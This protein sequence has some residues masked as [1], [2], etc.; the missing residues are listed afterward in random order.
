MKKNTSS[1]RRT[2]SLELIHKL[3]AIQK[4]FY[5]LSDLEIVYAKGRNAT[6]YA[7]NRAI[8]KQVLKRL[9]P[10]IYVCPLFN[11][12]IRLIAN[13]FYYPSYLSFESALSLY[14]ILSQI[15]YTM[16]FATTRRSKKTI[17]DGYE[18]EYKKVK[19]TQFF[20][21]KKKDQI[22]IADPEKALLDC[23]YFV[24]IGKG[25]LNTNE[26]TLKGIDQKRLKD[27]STRFP[28][29]TQ[30]AVRKLYPL[31]NQVTATI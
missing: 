3:K 19:P 25:R 8:K 30:V 14:G 24:T 6:K 5:T 12:D 22:Y 18:I 15:P 20:G 31:L 28:Q 13:L 23:I 27:Y 21:Y 10:N 11:Y 7:V 2:S 4:P 9:A 26:L 29:R 16:M 1:V 17:I